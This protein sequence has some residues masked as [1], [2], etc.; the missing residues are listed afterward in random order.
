MKAIQF[1][2]PVLIGFSATA[3][4]K[5]I[6]ESFHKN[7]PT[8]DAFR[9]N[10]DQLHQSMADNALLSN[11]TVQSFHFVPHTARLNSLGEQRME[12]YAALLAKDGGTLRLETHTP[13]ALVNTARIDAVKT[14][15]ASSGI[16]DN[17]IAMELGLSRGQGLQAV[18]AISV[19]AQHFA[20]ERE[21]LTDLLGGSSGDFGTEGGN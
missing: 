3:G 21:A 2:I 20:P 19:K 10:R 8:N 16:T 1:A 17:R 7:T 13:D 12:R 4:C 6:G 11:M 9:V 14:Y 15:L 18:E 5:H